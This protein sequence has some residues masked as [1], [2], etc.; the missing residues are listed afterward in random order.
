MGVT[1]SRKPGARDDAAASEKK[2]RKIQTRAQIRRNSI[3]SRAARRGGC[4]RRRFG[5]PSG[6][7]LCRR[8]QS[9]I[10]P[11]CVCMQPTRRAPAAASPVQQWQVRNELIRARWVFSMAPS[12]SVPPAWPASEHHSILFTCRLGRCVCV[13]A[14][15]LARAHMALNR[16]GPAPA[17]GR[18]HTV[19]VQTCK[20]RVCQARR[21]RHCPIPPDGCVVRARVC[22]RR[23]LACLRPNSDVD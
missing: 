19:I 21:R 10:G 20:R 11:C 3:K 22:R 15:R 1:H 18:D 7:A 2:R 17:D 5:P 16:A 13:A 8:R 12:R 9:D 23:R 6:P 4:R 14:R